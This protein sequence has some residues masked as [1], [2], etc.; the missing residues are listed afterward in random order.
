[1]SRF[2]TSLESRVDLLIRNQLLSDEN[3]AL[4]D[5]N[6]TLRMAG[7]STAAV[8]MKPVSEVS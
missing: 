8:P 6:T 4:S 5:E 2:P 7:L 3:A 1:M